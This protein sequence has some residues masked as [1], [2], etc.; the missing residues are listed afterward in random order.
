MMDATDAWPAVVAGRSWVLD[1]APE[2]PALVVDVGCGAGTFSAEA[3]RRG[4]AAVDVD[5]SVAMVGAVRTRHGAVPAALADA[6]SLPFAG[7]AAGLVHGERVLQWSGDPD[8]ALAELWRVTAAGGCLAVTDTDWATLIVDGPDPAVA[9]GLARTARRWI[10]HPVLARSLPRRLAALGATHVEVRADA[11]A[12]TAWDP[13]A[14]A[15]AEGP[16]GLPLTAIA[17]VAPPDERARL[18]DGV[19]AL[20]DLARSGPFFAALTLVTAIGRR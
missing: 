18:L 5:R 13:D 8:A 20:A 12:I 11:V 1:R 3:R 9:E 10:P 19:A 16:P 15:Q 4:H 14:P 2:R 6:S 7:G 17:R